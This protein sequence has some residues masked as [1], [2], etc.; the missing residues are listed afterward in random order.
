MLDETKRNKEVTLSTI[1][2][3]LSVA[4]GLM[5]LLYA[6]LIS[7]MATDLRDQVIAYRQE[8]CYLDE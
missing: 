5:C 7:V 3:I 6:I 4:F 1:I 8:G 2:C